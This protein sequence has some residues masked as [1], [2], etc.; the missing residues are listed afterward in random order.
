MGA[1]LL[2]GADAS[3]PAPIVVLSLGTL[4]Y[5]ARCSYFFLSAWNF[6]SRS[7]HTA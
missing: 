3:A 5:A 1:I 4:P 7:F 6:G 2:D